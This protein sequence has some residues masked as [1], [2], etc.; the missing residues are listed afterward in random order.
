MSKVSEWLWQI[1]AK[2]GVVQGVS[3]LIAL[4]GADN[5]GGVDTTTAQKVLVAVLV[6]LL[7]VLRNWLKQAKGQGYL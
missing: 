4:V 5:L 3:T 2:K 7:N 1:A 6:G